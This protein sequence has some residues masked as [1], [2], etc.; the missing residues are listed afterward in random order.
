MT[1]T[2]KPWER[3]ADLDQLDPVF[4]K[5]LCE[6]MAEAEAAGL[7]PRVGETYRSQARQDWLFGQGRTRP[8]RIVTW[9]EHSR[10]TDRLAADVYL[11]PAET[12]GKLT[13]KKCF[14]DRWGAIALRHHLQWGGRFRSY[15]G[16]HVEAKWQ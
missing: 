5:H 9:T 10:H 6:A 4:A 11:Y 12:G 16:P 3:C 13:W 8:G 2:T 14:F 7:G 1:A 15:D